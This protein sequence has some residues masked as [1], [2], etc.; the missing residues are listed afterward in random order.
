MTSSPH[1]YPDWKAPREDGE[2]FIWPEP[3][4][5]LAETQENHRKLSASDV[6]VQNVSFAELRRRQREWIHHDDGKLL[7]ADAHQSELH[8]AGVWVKRVLSHFAAARFDGSAAHFAVDTDAPKHLHLR[9][10]GGSEPITDDP[11][12]TTAQWAGL[13]DAPSPAHIEH[14]HRRL[15]ESQFAARPAVYDFLTSL[16]RLAIEQPKL[17]PALTNSM[18]E[19]DWSFELR[20]HA[21]LASPIWQSEPF[22]VFAHHLI[23]RAGPFA[24]I[25]NDALADFRREKKV[26]TPTRPM[27]DLAALET[28]AEIPFWLDQLDTG[29]RTRPSAFP[30]D[31]GYVLAAPNGDEF[32]FDAK[33]AGFEAAARLSAWLR[34]NQLRL[35][36]RALTLTMFLRLFVVDQFVHGIGGGRYDQITDRIIAAHFQIEPP[37]FAVATGTMYLPEAVGRSRVCVPCVAQDGHRLRHALLGPRKRELI[38][39]INAAPRKSAQRYTTFATMHRELAAAATDHPAVRRW[40]QEL[41]EAQIRETE[42]VPIFDR[43]LFYCL[44]PR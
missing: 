38:D 18:H 36:P 29:E 34:R 14:L 12:L 11:N 22:L 20:H 6:R 31:G 19:L 24:T 30:R 39:Q 4:T 42:E 21:M 23:A 7:I 35:S 26:R 5:L 28:A 13:L 44:Q 9:W 17:S 16:R 2:I 15:D 25:Y 43:E 3:R 32:D 37:R 27:P 1:A 10:I 41:R 8:H 40:E 33:T